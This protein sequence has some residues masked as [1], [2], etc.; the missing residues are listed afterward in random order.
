M[1]LTMRRLVLLAVAVSVV[2][3][4]GACSGGGSPSSAGS[5]TPA[6]TT[7]AAAGG[8]AEQFCSIVRQQ[9]SVLQATALT[10]LLTGGTPDAWK[11]YL[12]QTTAMNQQLVDAAPAEI[13]PSVQTLQAGALDLKSTLEAANYDVTK[14][15][16]A[17]L[18]QIL[19]TPDRVQAT[20]TLVAYVQTHCGID[21]TK[22]D[23]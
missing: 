17:K 4:A 16:A 15:G 12:D 6:A 5:Q 20:T 1:I 23:G 11:A 2:G 19:Q 22:V 18:L 21:L 9:K 13:K 7:A 14:V 10:S 3:A 8:S